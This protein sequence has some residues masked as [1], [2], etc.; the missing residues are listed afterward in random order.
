VTQQAQHAEGLTNSVFN[1]LTSGVLAINEQGGLL[2]L[3]QA[4]LKH[5]QL[6]A[7]ELTL[8]DYRAALAPLPEI[9]A[10]VERTLYNYNLAQ[11]QR[12]RIEIKPRAGRETTQLLDVSVAP[13]TVGEEEHGRVV[14]L[15]DVTEAENTREELRRNRTLSTVGQLTAQVA[16]EIYNPLGALKLNVELLEMQVNG[17]QDAQSTV[18]RLKRGLEHLS[19]IVLDLRY[20]TRP[21]EPER[22]PTD[23]NA[24][25][26]EVVELAGDRLERSHIFVKRTY[27]PERL[28]GDYDPLQLRKVFLN[29]L[30][31]AIEASPR[32]GEV[33]LR[34]QRLTT[35][36]AAAPL[37][38]VSVIDH[39]V[40]MSAET[41]RRI[42]EAFYSTKQH[43]TGLGMMIT[44]EIIK[45]HD[46]RIEIESEEGK[47]TTVTVY[48][49]G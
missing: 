31:N 25:L 7:A 48:L 41:K 35:Q 43:G 42:F 30:I 47:G 6:S 20:L 40:G 10:F 11:G 15:D 4:F 1:S 44:Q 3:N 29:L 13:L 8:Q 49:P 34:T 27:A 37:L 5:F 38:A 19:T 9:S 28:V 26:D 2:K 14:V 39:G 22:K 16:H 32:A 33:E 18:A 46:G 12:E 36:A 21:R 24:L 23:L 17:D 45:K